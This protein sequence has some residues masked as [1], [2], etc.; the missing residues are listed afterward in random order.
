LYLKN[1]HFLILLLTMAKL[2]TRQLGKNGPQ[3]TALGFGTMR[4]SYLYGKL[5]SDEERFKALD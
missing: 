3:A 2:P 4:L 5:L 1:Q